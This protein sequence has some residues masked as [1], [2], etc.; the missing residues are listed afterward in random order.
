MSERDWK[1]GKGF[2]NGLTQA[3]IEYLT[4][5]F[6]KAW[7]EGERHESDYLMTWGQFCPNGHKCNPYREKEL[8]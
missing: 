3:D 7:S 1:T 5:S 6:I 4:D 2:T 8:G